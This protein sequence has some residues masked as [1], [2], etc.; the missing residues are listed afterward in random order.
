V[1]KPITDPDEAL[2]HAV[3]EQVVDYGADA[4]AAALEQVVREQ[5][6]CA[7]CG[8]SL[9]SERRSRLYCGPAC[10]MKAYRA[11]RAARTST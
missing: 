5:A 9:A 11:R 3:R 4:V 10:R 1:G 2:V 6:R 7:V 8:A